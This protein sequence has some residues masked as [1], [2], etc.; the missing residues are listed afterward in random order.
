MATAAEI[1]RRVLNGGDLFRMKWVSDP[2]IRKDGSAVAYVRQSNDIRSDRQTQSISIV[3]VTTGAE[4][5][6]GDAAGLYSAPRWAPDG[7]RLA[8]L[9]AAEGGRS[10]IYVHSMLTG[11]EHAVTGVRELPRDIAW[12]PDGHAIAFVM[13]VPEPDPTLGAAPEKPDGASWAEPLKIITDLNYRIDG[14]GYA[15]HGYSHLFVIAA[16]GGTPRQLTFG[17]FSE[18]GPLSWSPDGRYVLLAGSRREDWKREPMDWSRHVPVNLNILR[19]EVSD[20]HMESLTD[21]TGPFGSAVYSPKGPQIAYLGFDDRCLGHQNVRLQIMDSD[22]GNSYSIGDSLDRSIN[23]MAWAP[24]GR[25]LYIGY[26]DRGI[27]K[28]AQVTLDGR[29]APVATNLAQSNRPNLPFSGGQ[30]SVAS[31]DAI[32]YTGGSPDRPARLYVRRD[33]ETLALIDP[34]DGLFSG[35]KTGDTTSL[36]VISSFDQRA[37]DAW[38]ITPPDFDPEKKY[39][40]I[41]EIHGGPYLSYG[42]VFATDL[43][44][45][46]AA[47]YIVVFANPRGSNSRGEEFANLI[48]YDYPNHD[49]DDLMS[50]VDAAIQRGSVDVRNLFVTGS[51]GGGTLTAWIVGSTHRFRAAAAQRP[52]TNWASWILTADMYS[53]AAFYWFSKMPW[54][55]PD[56]YWRHSPLSRVGR[57]TTPTLLVAGSADLRA[58]AGQAEQFYQALQLRHVPTALVEIPGSSHFLMRPSQMA[59]QSSA[60]LAWFER[61]KQVDETSDLSIT[62]SG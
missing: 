30:F 45:Y 25:S 49:F 31:N 18:T 20:G 32:A 46:A 4:M 26:V 48:H 28:I 36:P 5:P 33:G 7:Q 52:L 61:Y 38:V 50:V 15:R 47:G 14:E 9:F 21:R 19:V 16:E 57:V 53:Y 43:Q 41:L 12:S 42:P 55:D 11:T 27:T 17:P 44:L 23:S 8:Y 56:D 59:A 40:L 3:N 51:S 35:L 22:G 37:I 54:E 6:V 24:D 60:I 34:N 2:Q 29:V 13:F 62:G 1:P 39:P 10:Q 58:N